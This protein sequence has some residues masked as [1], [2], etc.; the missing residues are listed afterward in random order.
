MSGDPHPVNLNSTDDSYSILW[1]ASPSDTYTLTATNSVGS[2]TRP[3]PIKPILSNGMLVKDQSDN[4]KIYL[5]IDD[6]LRLIPS[7]EAYDKL[8]EDNL[9][10]IEIPSA[11]AYP[12]GQPLTK[13]TED[14]AFLGIDWFGGPPVYLI[15]DGTQRLI[16]NEEVAN[17]YHF[18]RGEWRGFDNELPPGPDLT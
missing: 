6:Q 17:R 4:D 2:D 12:L 13:D 3:I 15:V 8:F 18:N 16:V 5:M 10:I 7:K 14:D 9:D 11:N 1:T